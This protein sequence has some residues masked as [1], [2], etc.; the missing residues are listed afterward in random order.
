MVTAQ[1]QVRRVVP[2]GYRRHDRDNRR[3]G[4]TAAGTVGGPQRAP[5]NG[6]P[7]GL[8]R[9]GRFAAPGGASREE[10]AHKG[11][12]PQASCRVAGSQFPSQEG[13]KARSCLTAAGTAAVLSAR[14]RD[15]RRQAAQARLILACDVAAD[16]QASV[17]WMTLFRVRA[18]AGWTGAACSSGR[19]PGGRCRAGAERGAARVIESR[20][21]CALS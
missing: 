18:R 1:Q 21:K 16:E 10:T 17:V 8:P 6:V 5:V 3:P 2:A 13:R 9:I 19:S 20:D 4:R 14:T 12:I 15:V 11:R 7:S